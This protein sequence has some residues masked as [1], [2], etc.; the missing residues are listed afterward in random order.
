MDLTSSSIAATKAEAHAEPTQIA[1]STRLP[2]R[3]PPY[4]A[5]VAATIGNTAFK[6]LS[7]QNLRL[8]LAHQP[9][10]ASAFQAM[11]HQV[12][13]KSALPERERE[14]AII[15]TGALTRS[16]Y[17]WGMHVSIYGDKCKLSAAQI[18]EL[19]TGTPS[20]ALWTD[21][22]RLI[23]RVVD[24]LHHHSTVADATY[25]EMRTHWAEPQ[26]VELI[27]SSGFYHM[28]AFF[29]NS[30]AV[31][32]EHGAERFPDGIQQASVPATKD[33]TR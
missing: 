18:A 29:L 11:A 17:E 23:V 28:A 20:E 15:R 12:L 24:E 6:G 10:L 1:A 26:I 25:A 27:L 33:A 14:I 8:A 31:P 19:T 13:F 2:L 3:A 21:K 9:A 4:D 7:P 16:E 22:E 32:L 5:D 30:V